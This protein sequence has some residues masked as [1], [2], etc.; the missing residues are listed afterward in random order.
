MS[1]ALIT[2]VANQWLS[3]YTASFLNDGDDEG[4]VL[5]EQRRWWW[6]FRGRTAVGL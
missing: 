1:T 4:A 5:A 2:Q 6:K 3:D